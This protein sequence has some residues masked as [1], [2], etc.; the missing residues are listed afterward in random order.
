MIR[1]WLQQGVRGAAEPRRHNVS[2]EESG[3]HVVQNQPQIMKNK[4]SG[5]F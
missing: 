5:L 1:W 4:R 2:S 3:G